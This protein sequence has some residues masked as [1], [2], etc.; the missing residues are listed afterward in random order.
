[1]DRNDGESDNYP[2]LVDEGVVGEDDEDYVNGK[3]DTFLDRI[4]KALDQRTTP[5]HPTQLNQIQFK[6]LMTI[7]ANRTFQVKK[8]ENNKYSKI[9]H[10]RAK[11]NGI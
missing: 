6:I 9:N 3:Y 10:P 2:E 1:M 7:N 5:S 8:E 11:A 4:C